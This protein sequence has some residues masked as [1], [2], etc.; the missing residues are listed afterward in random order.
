MKRI[1]FLALPLLVLL[2]VSFT[3]CIARDT[4]LG[5]TSALVGTWAWLGEPY[6]VF[7]SDGSGT[8]PPNISINWGTGNGILAICNTPFMCRGNCPAP[9]EW[10]YV[11]DGDELTLNSRLPL[12]SAATLTYTR[13]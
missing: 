9:M 10:N 13:Q 8:M 12:L 11:L 4:E 7:N 1:K 6:Y 3:S 2:A 5:G